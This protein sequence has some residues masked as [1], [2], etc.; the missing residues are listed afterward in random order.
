MARR[1]HLP[2]LSAL[3]RRLR[4]RRH[5]R[6][7]R[8]HR[9]PRPPGRTRRRRGLAVA[10]LPVAAGRR[11]LR[12]GR[13]PRRRPALRRP[14]R[15]RHADRRRRTRAGCGSS[16]TWCPTTPPPSTPGSARRWPPAPAAPERQRYIFRD[17]RGPDGDEPPNNWQSVFGGPAWTR[18]TDADGR[19]ASGTCTCST[20]ASPTS[21]G[22]TRGPRRVRR[23]PAVLARPGRRRL[24]GRRRARP[25]QGGRPGRLARP[26]GAAL[27]RGHRGPA[28][29]DVGPGRRARHLPATGG[30]C[31]TATPASGSWSPRR[32][33]SRRSGWPRYVRPDEMHQ[34]FNFEYLEAPWTAAGP[35]R[36]DHPLAGRQRGGRRAHHLGA[37]QPRRGPARVPARPAGRRSPGRNGIGADDPQPDAALGPAPGPG[38]HPADAGPARLGLPLPG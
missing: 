8:H 30:R 23:H 24:P 10:V 21:T 20:P 6:P 14:R 13:L 25:G 34:A 35:A 32:G 37:V 15:R 31:W 16:S 36:G 2:D 1:R 5:R 33:C 27:R 12:R 17:G 22:T 3:V 38:G 29:A 11:R 4:R 18:I 28:P 7:A 9:P 26:A 19:P